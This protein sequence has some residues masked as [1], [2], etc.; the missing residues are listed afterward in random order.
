MITIMQ[1]L[2]VTFG[3]EIVSISVLIE[4][5]AGEFFL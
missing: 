4:D 1:F 3:A 2:N 5:E